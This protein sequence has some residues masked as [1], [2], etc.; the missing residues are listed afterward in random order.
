MNITSAQGSNFNLNYLNKNEKQKESINR[1][2]QPEIEKERIDYRK[3]S[4]EESKNLYLAYQTSNLMKSK[5]EILMDSEENNLTY[6]DI[7]D[8]NK[9]QNRIDIVESYNKQVNIQK[10]DSQYEMWA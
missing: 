2:I 10:S 6:K 4:N 8:V 1:E 7:R 5:I 9:S 3:L